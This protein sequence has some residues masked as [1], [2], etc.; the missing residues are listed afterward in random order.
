MNRESQKENL[1]V[2]SA[3]ITF[4]YIDTVVLLGGIV[5]FENGSEQLRVDFHLHTRKSQN[6]EAQE[7]QKKYQKCITVIHCL[8]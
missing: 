8:N 2:V 5:M 4:A 6:Q 1:S 3:Y 7:W